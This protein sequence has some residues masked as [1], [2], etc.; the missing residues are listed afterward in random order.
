MKIIFFGTPQ[1][2]A[3]ILQGLIDQKFDII[4]VV[5]NPDR[6]IK[7]SQLPI[8]S[9][10]KEVA[11]NNNLQLFQ[12]EKASTQEFV[13]TLRPLSADLFIVAAYGEIFKEKLL[14]LPSLGC[15][16]VHGSILPKYRGAA[17]VQHAILHGDKE[18]GVTIMRMARELDAGGIYHIEKVAITEQMTAGDLMEK[19]A[20]AGVKALKYV[21]EKLEKKSITPQP[22]VGEVTFAPK[23]KTED[24]FVDFSKSAQDHFQQIKAVTPK[25]GAWCWIGIGDEKKRCRLYRVQIAQNLEPKKLIIPCKVG[26]IEILELQLESK[27]KMDAETFLRG[28][29]NKKITF[30]SEIK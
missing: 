1:F 22:Q 30:N 26:Y 18:S 17:P 6:P 28:Y 5:T 12:P 24:A 29:I 27:Q 14:A 21:L 20:D 11:L 9:P 16:N 8:P 13:D 10:V 3:T 23:L 7:R 4:A 19:L 15:I 2:A 25:P